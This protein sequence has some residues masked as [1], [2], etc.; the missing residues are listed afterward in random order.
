LWWT[1]GI[2]LFSLLN[3]IFQQEIWLHT[4][5][6]ENWFSLLGLLCLLM[7]PWQAAC[8]AGRVADLL[9]T[10]LWRFPWRLVS[11]GAYLGGGLV[12]V[13]GIFCLCCLLTMIV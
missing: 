10:S 2:G 6:A 9:C 5:Q 8:T 1:I 7:L 12:L 3:L 4:P 13:P 11:W